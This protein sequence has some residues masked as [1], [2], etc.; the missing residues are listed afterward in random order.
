MKY[1]GPTI[2]QR[3]IVHIY[4][5]I[6]TLVTNTKCSES[7]NIRTLKPDAQNLRNTEELVAV[8]Q[9]TVWGIFFEKLYS[10]L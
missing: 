10:K 4:I 7:N 6:S 1:K 5:L 2:A 8:N 3:T 9:V